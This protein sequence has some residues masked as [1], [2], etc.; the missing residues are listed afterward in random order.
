MWSVPQVGGTTLGVPKK[1]M[2]QFWEMYWSPYLGNNHVGLR[3]LSSND[4][5]AQLN[6][7]CVEAIRASL[8]AFIGDYADYAM[9]AAAS[10]KRCST[11]GFA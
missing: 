8:T 5:F 10:C 4:P 6:G 11:C 9:F 3:V 1:R 7:L 2:V